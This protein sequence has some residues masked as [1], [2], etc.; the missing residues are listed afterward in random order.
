M[1]A[2]PMREV[3]DA[4]ARADRTFVT[5]VPD[6]GL[7]T[8]ID[9]ISNDRRFTHIACTREEE[10]VGL[11]S[12][13]G[14]AGRRGVL[15]TQNSGIGNTINALTS[16]VSFYELPLLLLVSMR[17]GMGERISAQIPMGR[18]TRDLLAASGVSM[19]DSPARGAFLAALGTDLDGRVAILAS[20]DH[21]SR[22]TGS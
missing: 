11:C 7:A 12:G 2:A 8:L 6:K 4:L 1:T 14:F 21:W 22:L 9:A 13:A 20:P 10:A 17:G 16:L 18:A 15:L 19:V 5:S 3:I